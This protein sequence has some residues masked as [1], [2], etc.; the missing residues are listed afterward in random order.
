M[1][2]K[3]HLKRVKLSLKNE[4]NEHFMVYLVRGTVKMMVN[5]NTSIYL[6]KTLKRVFLNGLSV[7]TCRKTYQS[8]SSTGHPQTLLFEP[9]HHSAACCWLTKNNNNNKMVAAQR[10]DHRHPSVNS[11][12]NYFG[13]MSNA[14][15]WLFFFCRISSTFCVLFIGW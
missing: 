8:I 1:I 2:V 11:F 7:K 6:V 5:H 10:L 14:K 3:I 12:I 4:W 13:P 15:K 9:A